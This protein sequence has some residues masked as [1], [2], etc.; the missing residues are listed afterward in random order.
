MARPA[1]NSM[2]GYS[3]SAGTRNATNSVRILAAT[4]AWRYHRTTRCPT[5]A[6]TPQAAADVNTP[7]AGIG[8][9]RASASAATTPDG[10]N[11]RASVPTFEGNARR[12]IFQGAQA[13]VNASVPVHSAAAWQATVPHS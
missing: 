11:Q 1:K 5:S 2:D 3:R 10:I 13:A 12:A 6:A 7:S 4:D 9:P 8:Q